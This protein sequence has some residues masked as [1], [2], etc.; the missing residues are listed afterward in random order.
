MSNFITL[1][2]VQK[3]KVDELGARLARV[4]IHIRRGEKR[5][6]RARLLGFYEEAD[7]L[8]KELEFPIDFVLVGANIGLL[9]GKGSMLRGRLPAALLGGVLGWLAGQTS[10]LSQQRFIGE[11]VEHSQQLEQLLAEPVAE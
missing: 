7:A 10:V 6:A 5:A 4:E 8:L 11:L 3:Q 1:T 9:T 2:H